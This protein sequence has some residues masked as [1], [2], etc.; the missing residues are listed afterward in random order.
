MGTFLLWFQGYTFNVVQHKTKIL[1]TGGIEVRRGAQGEKQMLSCVFACGYRT[2]MF[3]SFFGTTILFTICLPAI[4]AFTL[5]S[6]SAARSTSSLVAPAGTTTNPRSFP[7]TCTGI[8]ISS[9]AASDGS[10]FGQGA[11]SRLLV[12]PVIS[13][14]SCAI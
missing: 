13:H 8:S 12:S 2:T 14:N 11:F 5:S 1:T 4:A 6:A 10:Y 9:S 3:T 7:L